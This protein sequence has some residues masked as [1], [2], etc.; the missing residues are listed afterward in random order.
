MRS[1]SWAKADSAQLPIPAV[2]RGE[3]AAGV[4]LLPGSS[5]GRAGPAGSRTAKPDRCEEHADPGTVAN[6]E[7][8][9]P[10]PSPFRIPAPAS[11]LHALFAPY[12]PDLRPRRDPS[13][14][15]PRQ[16]HA[17][18]KARAARTRTR[19]QTRQQAAPQ[20]DALRLAFFCQLNHKVR[21]ARP[22]PY[23]AGI[24]CNSVEVTGQAQARLLRRP[25]KE[26]KPLTC[27]RVVATREPDR[28]EAISSQKSLVFN[29]SPGRVHQESSAARYN[30]KASA[31]CQQTSVRTAA[32]GS[33]D[34]LSTDCSHVR[35]V[36][37]GP[38]G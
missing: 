20:A 5:T 28:T 19:K 34:V 27:V 30:V 15:A 24:P 8:R 25:S 26:P 32:A 13:G 14:V 2:H 16:P 7:P 33:C 35:M 3:W 21:P 22:D 10:W 23:Q 36:P 9:M 37:I 11:L 38:L 4:D 6:R 17:A 31:P 18:A 12:E 1:I 29:R